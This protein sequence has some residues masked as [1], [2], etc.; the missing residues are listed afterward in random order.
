MD[1][2]KKLNEEG[3][4]VI[5]VTHNEA[6]AQYGNRIVQLHDGWVQSDISLIVGG[7]VYWEFAGSNLSARMMR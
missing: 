7:L 4:T 1:L 6:W 3:V 2:F 5:Q